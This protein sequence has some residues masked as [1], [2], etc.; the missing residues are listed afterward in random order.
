MG[1][2]APSPDD[3]SQVPAIRTSALVAAVAWTGLHLAL[4]VLSFDQVR[5]PLPYVAALA[6]CG[7][8]VLWTIRPLLGEPAR[9]PDL[10]VWLMAAS[11]PVV[12]LLDVSSLDPGAVN[13]YANWPAGATGV[14]LAGLVLRRRGWWAIF[15]TVGLVAVQTVGYLRSPA[16]DVQL[17]VPVL[18]AFP[19][20]L[21][22]LG[23]WAVRRLMQRAD[24]VAV[25]F[26]LRA[27]R[28]AAAALAGGS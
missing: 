23:S 6:L 15:A 16:G 11:V 28:D 8:G 12:E 25:E 27:A 17:A 13:G 9:F 21:W 22:L 18:L 24:R 5:H 1:G 4:A 14:L 7:V 19:S 20:E 10:P 2:V 3:L 26:R